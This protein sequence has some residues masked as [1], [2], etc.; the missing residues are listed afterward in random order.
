MTP[1]ASRARRPFRPGLE[2]LEDRTTPSTSW[3]TF[4]GNPQ[5]TGDAT[6]AAQPVDA[7]HWHTPVDLNP[8]G[9]SVHYGSP[10]FTPANT[11]IIPIKTGSDGGFEVAGRNG[12][13]G[14][15]LWT[16]PSDYTM[17]PH[18]WLPP[19]GPTLTSTGRLY[20]PGNGGTVY[21]VDNPDTP[22]ATVGGQLAFYG[23]ANYL[24]NPN[25]YNGSVFIDTPLT[26]DTNGAIYFGF[27]V[28]GAN[29]S[30][31]VGGGI[32]RIDAN[33][34]GSYVLASSAAD[35]S[36]SRAALS[37]SPALSNDGTTLYAVLNN[38]SQYGGY[39]VALDSTT[40]ATKDKVPLMDPRSNNLNVAGLIDVST[41]TPFVAPDNTVFTSVFGNPYNG[42][43]GFLLHFA[44]DLS[45]EYTPGA[46]GWDDTQSIVPA[47][48]VP[49]YHGTSSYL[50][51]S[52]YNDYVAAEVPNGGAGDNKVVLLDPYASEA[53]PN[54]D[55]DPNLR[56]MREVLSVLGP[57]PD[58]AFTGSGY[59]NAVR[60]W[61]INDTAIDP[62]TKS[63]LVNSEDGN[64]Y[65]WD[66]T[67]NTLSQAVHISLGIGEPY[68]PT[69][70]GPDGSV[71]VINGGTLFALGGLPGYSLTAVSTLNVAAVGQAV[72]LTAT[73]ASTSG[74][75]TP[76][77]SVT[78][79]DGSTFLAT[80]PL[81]NGRASYRTSF[82]NAAAHFLTAA[83]SGDGT[84]AAGSTTFVL[85]VLPPVTVQSAV[86]N[87]GSAQRSMVDS[88]TVSFPGTVTVAVGAF[89]LQ[90]LVPGGFP[91]D[92]SNLLQVSTTVNSSNQTVATLTF[93]GS[94]V[95]GGSLADGRYQLLYQGSPVP[96]ANFF[97]LFGDVNGDGQVDDTDRPAFLAAYRSRKGMANY[98]WYFDVN[99]DGAI[100]SVDY[101]QFQRR[102]KTRL[103]AD[104]SVST[105]P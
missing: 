98:R 20:F 19:Y 18:D 41:A 36:V 9:A 67:T 63:A 39:L 68:T 30:N 16:L 75:P 93:A 8:T 7:I 78:F 54:N 94:G 24:A 22:G 31:L 72:T 53:D 51:F 60:E 14:N 99:A 65:R 87:D 50:V 21:Y 26:A 13:T 43:R 42:S 33:G 69:S 96:V 59:P 15:L 105:L 92:L 2:G 90:E 47:A 61:C 80:V 52:K 83:Y 70:I 76:T 95:L 88:I 84:Y 46:F 1:M 55:G 86:V 58:T 73:L 12:A 44:A 64:L 101:F 62:F 74:G 11:V 38:T 5:H 103:N 81:V 56:V 82:A 37:A 77:G 57:T 10:V 27:M 102:Y 104:G 66:L 28:T 48:A 4:A 71:Y 79:T 45:T 25:G 17:P 89:Q 91:M 97:R 100:D 49:S 6:V 34:N 32:A 23:L 29:P 40:L 85:R 35:G 3:F